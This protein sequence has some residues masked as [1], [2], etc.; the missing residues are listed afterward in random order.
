MKADIS[1]LHKPDI[2][3]LQRQLVS[4]LLCPNLEK[5]TMRETEVQ[6]ENPGS[7]RRLMGQ[8]F[9]V[10]AVLLLASI[11][12]CLPA[13]ATPISACI[14]PV[15]CS[16]FEST[17]PFLLPFLAISGDVVLLDQSG[18]TSDVFRIF[19]D[20][21]DTGRGTGLGLQTIFFSVDEM[22]L[23]NP[24]TLSANAVFLPENQ[25]FINGFSETDYLGNG[26]LYRLFSGENAADV[27]EPSTF[28]L[29][30]LGLATISGLFR[31]RVRT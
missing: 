10:V 9:A 26:T 19:N 16:I 13:A 29:I 14:S 3:T 7:R 23:P 18:G 22:N 17:Q 24:A 8:R 28:G 31:K 2:L 15:D 27:P 6:I 5:R 11:G 25:T 1:T 21:V 12:F 4:N 20:F 30:G